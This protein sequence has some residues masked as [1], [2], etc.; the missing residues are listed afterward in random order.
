MQFFFRKNTAVERSG[1]RM[2]VSYKKN[3][4]CVLPPVVTLFMHT[5]PREGKGV[6]G[7][8]SK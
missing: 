6:A 3:C 7:G 1:M 8:E 4:I 2:I 5:K